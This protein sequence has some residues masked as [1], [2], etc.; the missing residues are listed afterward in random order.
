MAILPD[1]L[2]TIEVHGYSHGE[3]G[4]RIMIVTET[5]RMFSAVVPAINIVDATIRGL[6]QYADAVKEKA[7]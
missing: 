3:D 6:Q 4:Y 5:G 2:A 7:I 1:P